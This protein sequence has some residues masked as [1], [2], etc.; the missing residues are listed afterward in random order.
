MKLKLAALFMASVFLLAAAA[1]EAGDPAP[2]S[3]AVPGDEMPPGWKPLVIPRKAPSRFSLVAD[4][5]GVVLRAEAVATAGVLGYTLRHDPA[6][7][8]LLA[9]RWKIDHVLD[10]ADL[11]IKAGDDFAARVYVFFD[12]PI[13]T[14]SF[15]ERAKMTL[16]KLIYGADLPTAALCYVWDNK[17]IA[18]TSVWSAYTSR[19]RTIVL[20]SGPEKTKQWADETRDV[21]DDF[22]KAFGYDAPAITGIAAGNDTDQTRETAVAW[23][24]DFSFKAK[25]AK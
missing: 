11:G 16:A 4:D 1:Q 25:E 5:G 12:V 6:A 24:G 19:V 8:P 9:W 15:G 2:F 13:D 17:H 7:R 14:L 21:A 20:Q 23:F 18:G 3:R 10:K 22:R